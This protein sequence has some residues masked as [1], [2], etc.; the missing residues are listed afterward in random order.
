MTTFLKMP[1]ITFSTQ[2]YIEDGTQV[3]INPQYR[4]STKGLFNL[5]SHF[6]WSRVNF[7]V[8]DLPWYVETWKLLHSDIKQMKNE[9][10]PDGTTYP[11]IGLSQLKSKIMIV[12]AFVLSFMYLELTISML[13]TC[14]LC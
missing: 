11:K 6:Q 14:Q 5:L 4:N 3:P 10:E 8:S 1:T 2:L 13:L 9:T 12:T 7:I